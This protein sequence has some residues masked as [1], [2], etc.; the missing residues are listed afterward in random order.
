MEFI[1]NF[2]YKNSYLGG[3]PAVTKTIWES[4]SSES[5]HAPVMQL[6]R[7]GNFGTV[8]VQNQSRVAVI[9]VGCG[10]CGHL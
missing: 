2:S 4:T 1:C 5:W 6:L 9:Q 7:D 3:L 8:Q 10:L